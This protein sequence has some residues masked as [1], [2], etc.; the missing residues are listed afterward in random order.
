MESI[1]ILGD[2]LSKNYLINSLNIKNEECKISN[3]LRNRFAAN[4]KIFYFKSDLPFV[5]INCTL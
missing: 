5:C 4:L 2:D 3:S 1:Y